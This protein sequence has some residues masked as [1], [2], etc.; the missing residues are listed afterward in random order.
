MGVARESQREGALSRLERLVEFRGT[1]KSTFIVPSPT[2]HGSEIDRCRSVCC[3]GHGTRR[4]PS[5]IGRCK[6]GFEF[7]D[8]VLVLAELA[9]GWGAKIK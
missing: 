3:H 4:G 8:L 7:F 6:H 1:R 5:C 9:F 2:S